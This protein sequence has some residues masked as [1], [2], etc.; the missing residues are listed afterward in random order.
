[1]SHFQS[2]GDTSCTL[3]QRTDQ[4]STGA[5]NPL[6]WL[7]RHL[8]KEQVDQHDKVKPIQRNHQ[9]NTANP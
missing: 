2:F 5:N 3:G 1:M 4:A 7:I 9:E 6:P 8:V